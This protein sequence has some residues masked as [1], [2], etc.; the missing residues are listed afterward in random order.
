MLANLHPPFN[1]SQLRRVVPDALRSLRSW[2][3]RALGLSSGEVG[4]G[5][6]VGASGCDGRL[7]VAITVLCGARDSGSG[8]AFGGREEAF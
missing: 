1:R 5:S 4:R 3:W 2:S 8:Q 7:P 6:E